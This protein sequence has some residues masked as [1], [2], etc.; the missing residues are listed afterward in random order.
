MKLATRTTRI[1]PSPTLQL[2]AT[3]KALVAQGQQIFDFTAG[4][5][6]FDS[7]DVAKSAAITAIREGFTKYTAV[8]GID[9]L[10]NAIIDKFQKDQGLQYTRS[11]ILVSCGA[12]HTLFNLALALF[13]AGDEVIIP[14]PY[15]VSYPEQ[16]QVA[17]ATP[18]FLPTEENSGYDIDLDKLK[19]AV[20]SR[21]KALILNSPCNPTGGIY[22]RNTL[23]GVAKLASEHNF[24]VI[25]DEIYEKMIYD[26]HKHVSI[27]SISPEVA[28]RTIIVNGVSKT[29]SMTGWRI[30]YAAGPEPLIKAMG[31]IQ[32]QS[33][34]NPTSI[35]QK[36]AIG[37]LRGGQDFVRTMVQEL[38]IRRTTMV[39]GLNAIAGIQCPMPTGAFYAFPNIKDL[40]GRRFQE[41]TLSSP[42]ALADFLLKEAKVACVPGEPFGAPNHLRFSY[43]PTL[44]VIQKGLKSL[45]EAVARLK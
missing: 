11:Q 33:T 40:L 16:V 8:T 42:F 14:A 45:A 32:S 12:K 31:D 4:E 28:Q 13:E 44:E 41:T 7:P 15:W 1:T 35:A 3:V 36:A 43:T 10:K 20:T 24:L 6:S 29:Y 17:D 5:P 39:K 38:D 26:N 23:E 2:S 30:G 9:D 37:A 19:A 34:S 22:H 21:T 25:S 27:A 18:V